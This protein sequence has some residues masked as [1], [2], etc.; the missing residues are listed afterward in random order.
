M[1]LIPQFGNI[2]PNLSYEETTTPLPKEVAN[3]LLSLNSTSITQS[4]N[5]SLMPPYI[6]SYKYLNH[7]GL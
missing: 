3:F 6:L 5:R 4:C 7:N 2:Q 1:T